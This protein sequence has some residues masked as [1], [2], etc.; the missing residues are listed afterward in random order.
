[1]QRKK[2]LPT[3]EA[4]CDEDGLVFYCDGEP[5]EDMEFSWDD[6]SDPELVTEVAEEL[7]EYIDSDE[8]EDIDNPVQ[9]VRQALR[10]LRKTKVAKKAREE[11]EGE[12][13][14]DLEGF[15]DDME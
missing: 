8:L 7:V 2:I 1:M 3:I 9:A 14:E 15:D 10:K 4:A 12:E 13:E 5:I 6:L 11:G